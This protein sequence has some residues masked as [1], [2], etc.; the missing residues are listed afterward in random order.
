[1]IFTGWRGQSLTAD[2]C[3]IGGGVVLYRDM[4]TSNKTWCVRHK[5]GWCKIK[6]NQPYPESQDVVETVCGMFVTL[7]L[8]CELRMATCQNC[9]S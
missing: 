8:G 5:D 9:D 3:R 1:M 2:R 7:P 4:K 6:D